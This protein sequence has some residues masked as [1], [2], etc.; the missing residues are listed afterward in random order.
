MAGN[1]TI[2]AL[3]VT[4][5]L[6]S[7]AFTDGLSAAQKHLRGVGR[8]MQQVGAQMAGVGAAMSAAITA[9][10]M[11]AA[12]I[13]VREAVEMRDALGQVKD[14][15]EG[16]GAAA[17]R[18]L[19]Q[20]EA[21][22]AGLASRSLY[23]D[24]EILRDVSTTLLRF[25]NIAEENFDRA[26]Q[27]V[28]NYAAATKKD[29]PAAS[30]AIGR[31]LA[32]PEKAAARLARAGITLT[33]SQLAQIDAFN[34]AGDAAGAQ[35]VIL[36][37]LE[38]RYPNAAKAAL[39]AAP[40][41]VRLQKTFNDMAGTVGK[42]MLPAL[43][44]IAQIA[45]TMAERF[46]ALSPETQKFIAIGLGLAAALGPVL[47][48]LGAVVA[49]LGALV[50]T[51]ALPFLLAA[52][53]AVAA[54]SAAFAVWGK[55]LMPIVQAFGK[56]LVEAIGPMIPPMVAA[57]KAAFEAMAPVIK[58]VGEAFVGALGPIVITLLR[59]LAANVTAAF[60]IIGQAFRMVGAILR[61]DWSTAW[62][63]AGSLVM[64]IVKGLGSI[65][66]AVFPGITETVGRMVTGVTRW[67]TGKLFDVLRGVIAKVKGVS[68]AFFRLYDAV[69]G[70]SFVPDMVEGVADWMA[71]LDA[72][73]VTPA[74]RATSATAQAF[75]DL[76]D[77]VAAVMEGLLT[78]LE[79]AERDY[80]KS[81][82][83]LARGLAAGQITQGE[84]DQAMSRLDRRRA[85][86]RYAAGAGTRSWMGGA[87]G[88][89][90]SM[91][92][93]AGDRAGGMFGAARDAMSEA[94]TSV[95]DALRN[96]SDEME[97]A[98]DRFAHNFARTFEGLMRG[99]V[100]GVLEEVLSS[101]LRGSLLNIGRMIHGWGSKQGGWMGDLF[102][103]IPG[104][105]T[106]GSFRVGGRAG[107]DQNLVAFR[108]SKGEMVDI[109]RP[110]QT[111][112]VG[113]GM[114]FDLRG[115]VMTADLLRQM[116][117]MAAAAEDRAIR[118]SA[119]IARRGAPVIQQR[120]ARLG[121]V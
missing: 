90:G 86:D 111:V 79:R 93:A 51:P 121:T 49:A 35:A 105:A 74:Q 19:A 61:G 56:A 59:V 101:V 3:R 22:A 31:A 39:D 45:A 115:A 92:S 97:A 85:D 112:P 68:D 33:D 5:G 48:V 106:G 98:G 66:E 116:E 81:A 1:A 80:A 17:G 40:P 73:M 30:M 100:R 13:A 21:A 52:A 104:F 95:S 103:M 77:D 94:A 119:G 110:G 42:L 60:S 34:R 8:Q 14:A 2:G 82:G 37:A 62:N 91:F 32:D 10:I 23:E 12:S 53:A 11:A 20:L 89:F 72:V 99:D 36:S 6:D 29:L 57:M 87:A 64:S 7:A 38:E 118:S 69:V 26:Q 55:E 102:K 9:P 71:K 120:M 50:A 27:A 88:G 18:S 114:H 84:Y 41:L 15:L 108:A 109:R 113:S 65:V 54:V 107:I 83:V 78:D 24:D 67:L 46:K 96:V 47:V 16:V 70:H 63:A 4:L 117:G 58:F 25:G 75:Q 76:R 44:R 28:I 43:D